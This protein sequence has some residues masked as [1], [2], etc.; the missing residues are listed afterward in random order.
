LTALRTAD[1]DYHLPPEL[2]A[3]QAVEPRD[4]ARL[5]VADRHAGPLAHRS[6][7]D[8]DQLLKPGD[9][10]VLNR[11]KVIPARLFGRKESGGEVEVLLIHRDGE[12]SEGGECW[13][14][15]VRGKVKPGSGIDLGG[16]RAVVSACDDN[17]D[18]LIDFPVGC[19]VLL[20]AER[21]GHVPLPPYIARGDTASD[22]ERYQ[23]IF[24]DRPGSVA[25]PTASLHLTTA[26]LKRIAAR[27]VSIA[28]VEL[29]IGPG[30][31]KPVNTELLADYRIHAEHCIC[32]AETVE[33][34]RACH[35][36]GGRVIAA[37]T[38][39]VRTLESAADQSDGFAPFSGWTHLFMHPPQ[40]PRVVDGLLTN[41]HLPR[42]S[43]L[44]LVACFT[45]IERLRALYSEAIAQ[46]YR[47]Y[48]YGDAM[49]LLPGTA[50]QEPAQ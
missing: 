45:G 20:L 49:L 15:L 40:Q 28:K 11:T 21:I 16:V 2:I 12:G 17:G 5:L 47:F 3:Q 10:L 29:A 37:G 4:A 32:P 25:A 22:R 18:R 50:K 33:A 27:G 46:K 8:L 35:A 1:F 41:F 9:L 14:C 48:S 36:R 44:M 13:R 24:A 23:T 43:L 31:F 39:V 42:S 6:V 7:A 34:V 38:T 19:D 26:L 30:T